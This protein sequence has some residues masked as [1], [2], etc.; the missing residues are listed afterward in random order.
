MSR[1]RSNVGRNALDLG[2][3]LGLVGNIGGLVLDPHLQRTAELDVGAAAGHVSRD[4]DGAGHAGFGDDI[5]FLFVEARVQ[6]REQFRRFARARRRIELFHRIFVAEI[7]LLVSVLLQIFGKNLGLLDRGGADQYRL[8]PRIGALDL[9]Q[10]RRV[11]L[12][13]GAINLVV[14]VEA[15]HLHIG[16]DFHDFELVDVEQFVGFGSGGAGH[17]R[18]LLVHA[19][20][21]LERD[22]GQRLVFRLHRLMLLGFQRLVQ[23]F[24]IAPARH[25]AAGEFVDDDDLAVPDDVILVALEQRVRAQ[26]LIDVVHGRD[27]LDLVQLLLV[28]LELA[29]VAQQRLHLLHAGFGQRRGALLLVDV[30]IGF[31]QRRDVAVDGIV[32]FRA[33]VERPGNDQRRP[34]LVDQDRVD[35]VDDGEE[36]VALGFGRRDLS[37]GQQFGL[38]RKLLGSLS[39]FFVQLLGADSFLRYRLSQHRNRLHSIASNVGSGAIGQMSHWSRQLIAQRCEFFAF[40]QHPALVNDYAGSPQMQVVRNLGGEIDCLL[41]DR[42]GS[43]FR[44]VTPR[45]GLK[46]DG[47]SRIKPER[48]VDGRSNLVP[49]ARFQTG[50]D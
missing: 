20:V 8:Q 31:V 38:G 47:Q 36:V 6:H 37:S 15:R 16:R 33:V 18:E 44:G 48:P 2:G 17:A 45:A 4:G 28:A 13:L 25:H 1:K 12:A 43:R 7:D 30:V 24:R 26:R 32:E 46:F 19:E 23:A 3:L 5:G 49:I 10:D 21:V 34:R 29:G 9:G 39:Q 42:G 14:L 41:A 50:L 22:R 40:L 35:F 11:F 27:V